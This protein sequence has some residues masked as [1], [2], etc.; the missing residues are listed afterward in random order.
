MSE[1]VPNSMA[2][3]S[4]PSPSLTLR[5]FGYPQ[6]LHNGMPVTEFESDKSRAI[7]VYLAIESDRPHGR[8]SLA[9]MF[10]PEESLQ[11]GRQN[12]RQALYS[13]RRAFGQSTTDAPF[14]TISRQ[15]AR[16]NIGSDYWTDIQV[17]DRLSESIRLHDH[18][19]AEACPFCLDQARQA[20]DLYKGDFLEGF[21]IS[22]A[23]E[24]DDWQRNQADRLR[25]QLLESL[26]LLAS[27]HELRRE[28]DQ[29]VP[30]YRRAVEL[31]EFNEET[32]RG[33]IRSLA[34]E[35]NPG[36]ALGQYDRLIK[37]LAAE[38]AV[39]PE[40]ETQA[41]AQRIRTGDVE[42]NHIES[43]NPYKG[44]GPFSETDAADFFGRENV[45]NELLEAIEQQTFIT[46]TG[47]SGS[48]KSSVLTAGLLARM[49]QPRTVDWKPLSPAASTDKWSVIVLRPG[50]EPFASLAHSLAD[51]SPDTIDVETLSA[52]LQSGKQSLLDAIAGVMPY[53]HNADDDKESTSSASRNRLLLAFDQFEELFTLNAEVQTQHDF[54]NLLVQATQQQRAENAHQVTILLALRVDF[55]VQALGYRPLADLIQRNVI[56]LAPM[57]ENEL[58]AAI[59]EPAKNRGVTYEPGLVDRL[60]ADVGLEVGNLP[61]LQF[62][63]TLLW[64]K[65]N[66][67]ILS[68]AAYAEIG[69]VAGAL[70]A[71]ADDVFASLPHNDQERARRVLIRMVRPGDGGPD[72]RRLTRRQDYDVEDWALI[73]KLADERLVVTNRIDPETRTAEITH[74]ALI[75]HWDKMKS[76]L[77]NDRVFRNWHTRLQAAQHQWEFIHGDD[78]A[79]LRGIPLDEAER[80]LEERDQDIS[81]S[82][83]AFIQKSIDVRTQEEQRVQAAQQQLIQNAEDLAEA[84][85]QR[86]ETEAK[87]RRRFRALST[88]IGVALLLAVILAGFAWSAARQAEQQRRLALTRQLQAQSINLQEGDLDIAVLLAAESERLSD[89]TSDRTDSLLGLD[90][91]PLAAGTLH[92]ETSPIR[93]TAISSDDP[94]TLI[95]SAE[96]RTMLWDL[97]A[98]QPITTLAGITTDSFANLSPDGRRATTIDGASIQMWDLSSGQPVGQPLTEHPDAID[99]LSFSKDGSRLVTGSVDGTLLLRNADDGSVLK[100]FQY[101]GSGGM[102]LGEGGH[103]LAMY[104]NFEEGIGIEIWDL[105][106]GK[107]IAGPVFGH[108]GGV[109]SMSMSPD[110]SL[111]ATTGDDKT[112]R[113]WDGK[114]A[115][116]VGEP[117]IGHTGRV[118]TADFSPDGKTLAT[119]AT[120]NTIILWNLATGEP[121][122]PPLTGHGNW[123]RDVL[124]TADGN[125]LISADADGEIML[126]DLSKRDI[127]RGHTDRV[128]ALA[129]SDDGSQ[130]LTGGFD[131]KINIW[132]TA[133]GALLREVPSMHDG[134]IIFAALSPNRKWI[135]TGDVNGNVQLW[136]AHTMEPV[137]AVLRSSH[138]SFL[139]PLAFSPDDRILATGD[140]D[141]F[142]NL[143]DV[144][145]GTALTEPIHAHDAWVL[146]LAFSPD[147]KTLASGGASDNLIK[148]WQV[149]DLLANAGSAEQS[150]TA[151]LTGHENWVSSLVFSP[152]GNTLVSGSADQMIRFWDV[153][154]ATALDKA[155]LSPGAQ[156]WFLGWYPP[157]DGNTLVSLGADGSVVWWDVETGEPLAPPLRTNTETESMTMSANGDELYIGA[158]APIAQIW[159]V[160]RPGWHDQFCRIAN[161]NLTPEEWAEYLGDEPYHETC[162]NVSEGSAHQ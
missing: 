12:L 93:N 53:E 21:S 118:L 44:I 156:V 147:G 146:S 94:N 160:E 102:V 67:G 24:F 31:D 48:G 78:S 7:L 134:S 115:E 36:L 121:L 141:G 79:L 142:I 68:H 85:R 19:R 88:G 143:W 2:E 103:M 81:V 64:E 135:A 117:L 51:V 23:V 90:Y 3:N 125:T 89:S 69:G 28:Y 30:Y 11:V 133:T 159:R 124:F 98:R 139:I 153:N 60:I 47:P 16:F 46:L 54:I 132:D 100:S 84:Q 128:R 25:Y 150:P 17:F 111:L 13:L 99:F 29:A 52:D 39:E 82:E 126:W 114:T 105:D 108:D 123:I 92:G 43:Q 131:G 50:A 70:A 130:L 91:S 63:L 157:D 162:A 37:L 20:V 9:A 65:H 38:M 72:T 110:G 113:L 127:L 22:D 80:W 33:L 32:Q 137:R 136:D 149:D 148:L 27:Y 10:W 107:Q 42:P 154:S 6:V 1:P 145:S 87:G 49:R 77:S 14:L 45:V 122:G 62:A 15:N 152:D 96:G 5:F 101:D 59:L 34:L 83:K 8:E 73:R 112:V 109:E 56:L 71:Y 144:E 95:T 140:L 26:K 155:P 35:G 4:M 55:M 120:D 18:H 106:Q 97:T 74:E 66:K 158:V 75:W 41:L 151:T 86:A 161:R 116:P 129:L 76:W 57:D 104:D 119:G 138:P 40:E 58:R 61:L